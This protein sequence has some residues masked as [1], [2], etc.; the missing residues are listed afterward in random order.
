MYEELGRKLHE[1]TVTAITPSSLGA[2]NVGAGPFNSHMADNLVITVNTVQGGGLLHDRSQVNPTS[3]HT[4][5]RLV[6]LQDIP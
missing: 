4:P 5:A 3:Y 6:S 1:C 2:T